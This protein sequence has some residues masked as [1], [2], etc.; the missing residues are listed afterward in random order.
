[1]KFLKHFIKKA[2]AEDFDPAVASFAIATMLTKKIMKNKKLQQLDEEA[3]KKLIK[4]IKKSKQS[5][6]K[7]ALPPRGEYGVNF[8]KPK[9]DVE[10]LSYI[11]RK[12]PFAYYLLQTNMPNE[13]LIEDPLGV[14]IGRLFSGSRTRRIDPRT[15]SLSN[16]DYAMNGDKPAPF[17]YK[18]A[19]IA[20]QMEQIR[21]DL[22]RVNK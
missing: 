18:P 4:F 10:F 2:I 17:G 13:T 7:D 22:K 16:N 21:R 1:M 3:R 6:A 20:R 8:Y 5:V 9:K 19:Y 12:N 11:A 15:G 14:R